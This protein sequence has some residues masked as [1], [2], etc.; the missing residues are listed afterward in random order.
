MI[1][2]ILTKKILPLIMIL[3]MLDEKFLNENMILNILTK[4]ILPLIILEILTKKFSD[5]S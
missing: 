1:L 5:E 2:N 4:K 3:R